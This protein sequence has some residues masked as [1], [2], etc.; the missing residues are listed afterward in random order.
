MIRARPLAVR[1]GLAFRR[2]PLDF[3][4]S[5]DDGGEVLRFRAGLTDFVVLKNPE[6]IHRVLV[7]DA[8]LYGEGKWTLRGERVMR[9]CLITREGEPHRERRSLLQPGFER[10]RLHARAEAIVARAI[11][12][13]EGWS[14][15]QEV[16]V[17]A[18]MAALALSASAEALFSLELD[19]EAAEL[20]GALQ[21]MLHEIPRPGLPWPAGRELAAARRQLERTVGAALEPR[22]AASERDGDLLSALLAHDRNGGPAL[23]D[24]EIV[25]E[26][27]SL[28]IASIDTT[29]GTL[30][31]A[32][33]MLGATPRSRPPSTA[34]SQAR[35]PG[36][37]PPPRTCPGC[38]TSR[39]S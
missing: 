5:I 31:W 7:A 14:D 26:V 17:R 38:P 33:L 28:L 37:R 22:R 9:D 20:L 1:P 34:S 24:A 16:E 6:T 32:W 27:V 36:A 39:R 4:R 35:S 12:L 19:A 25:D 3:L 21:T 11:R 15:G 18:Q 29:P 23:S 13:G 10:A 2:E 8:E 30:A